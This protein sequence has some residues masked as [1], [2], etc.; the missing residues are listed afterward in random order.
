MLD[1]NRVVPVV[2]TDAVA[3]RSFDHLSGVAHQD[4]EREQASGYGIN[5]VEAGSFRVRTDGAWQEIGI[6]S[7]F[8]TNPGME[9]SCA[10]DEEHPADSC[11][12]LA[13]SDEAVESA[14]S[15]VVLG[16]RPVCPLTNRLAFLQRAL[17]A[18]VKGDEARLEAIAAA[19]LW[20]LSSGPA[21]QPLFRPDRLA[22]YAARVEY[23]RAL[24]EA[25][26]AEPL[27][28]SLM[29]RETGMSVF[30]FARIF[31]ELEGR[32]PHRVLTDV[33]LAH[34]YERLRDG[35]AVTDACFAVG[36][37]S[38]SHF[39]TT[40]RRRYGVR[41]SDIMRDGVRR[42]NGLVQKR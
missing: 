7:L 18:S 15:A 3:L 29:A 6:A 2:R 42:K 12:S 40:F 24:I 30:H 9:F 20:S 19:V 25:R 27:S 36:F 41:P 8:V 33:R 11:L 22:W 5:F 14:R 13:Y 16:H 28:L 4:P 32:P 23:A 10:H 37:G 39:V 1:M 26:Y 34:A 38:L 31:A 21:R 35:A 17:R